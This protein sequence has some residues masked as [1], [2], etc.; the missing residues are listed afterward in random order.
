MC[1]RGQL[2]FKARKVILSR[3]SFFFEGIWSFFFLSLF[4]LLKS[5]DD[6]N[7]YFDVSNISMI[8][9]TPTMI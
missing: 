9:Y 8:T 6:D 4:I 5:C 2:A 7:I 3:L 1:I